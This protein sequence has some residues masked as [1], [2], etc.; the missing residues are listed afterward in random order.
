MFALLKRNKMNNTSHNDLQIKI[1]KTVLD[2][3]HFENPTQEQ[4]EVLN[5][6]QTFVHPENEQDFMVVC[7]SAGTGKS[8]IMNAVVKYLHQQNTKVQVCA[9]TA[10]AARL[11]SMKTNDIATTVHSMVFSVK[12]QKNKAQINFGL[13]NNTEEDYTIYIIDEASMINSKV[14]RNHEDELFVCNNAILDAIAH[15]VKSGNISNKVI[16]VGDRYQL[17]PV[18]EIDSNALYPTYLKNKFTWKGSEYY[19]NEVKRQE[20]GC[21]ILKVATGI[22]NSIENEKDMPNLYIPS[23]KNTWEAQRQYVKDLEQFG[24]NYVANIACTIKQNQLFNFGVRNL[25]FGAD[26]LPILKNEVLIVKRNWKRNGVNLSNGD[27][28]IVKEVD[29][30]RKEIVEGMT[31][32]PVLLRAKNNAGE[33]IEILDTIL[34][35]CLQTGKA[36]LGKLKED[37]L[38]HQRYTKNKTYSETGNIEDDR[39]LGA[40]RAIYGYS[41][42]CNT[43]QGGEWEKVYLNTFYMP[44][45]RWAYTGVTRAKQELIKY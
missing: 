35:D 20:D 36:S 27:T 6:I 41:I 28:V 8:S 14:V 24:P 25:R 29:F 22:R 12:S 40:I 38:Y 33:E 45:K 4:V 32:L 7:G 5:A 16:F 9:P 42:T 15:Y 30:S 39:Y 23:V 13:K 31:F 10:R 11:I 34:L 21:D 18:G 26:A 19:L 1:Q 2:F 43:A 3:L 44:D 37:K 17:A